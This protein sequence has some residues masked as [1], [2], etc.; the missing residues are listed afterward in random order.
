MILKNWCEN[1]SEAVRLAEAGSPK[2]IGK[3]L[4]LGF[5]VALVSG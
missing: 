5:L 4:Q 2:Q 3:A 1:I